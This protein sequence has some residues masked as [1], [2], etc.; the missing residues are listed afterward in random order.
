LA[1]FNTLF[2]LRLALNPLLTLDISILLENQINGLPRPGSAGGDLCAPQFTGCCA[3]H[4]LKIRDQAA[5]ILGVTLIN[6]R[7]LTQVTLSLCRFLGQD[8]ACKS[9]IAADFTG[10][11]FTETLSRAAI[12]FNLWHSFSP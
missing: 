1:S 11:S 12:G 6:Q 2:R 7:C 4:P 10:S 3:T 8:V 5:D 9:L